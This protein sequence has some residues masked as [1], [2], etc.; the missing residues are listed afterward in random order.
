MGLRGA[1][2]L[3]RARSQLTT[4]E[5]DRLPTSV[6]EDSIEH[7]LFGFPIHLSTT[8]PSFSI[9]HRYHLFRNVD[10]DEWNSDASHGLRITGLLHSHT[11]SLLLDA[12]AESILNGLLSN[13]DEL[14]GGARFTLFPFAQTID[15]ATVGSEGY[16]AS[17]PE[18]ARLAP[19][20]AAPQH[21][22]GDE[23]VEGMGEV[24]DPRY[25]IIRERMLRQ[26]SSGCMTYW[27]A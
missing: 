1:D 4:E 25:E 26:R 16:D 14:G 2:I 11:A 18:A 21:D 27:K 10:P 5:W 20:T 8:G 9:T 7:W 22:E 17:F 19:S 3:C 12:R 23:D 15:L 6:G 13:D 24:L